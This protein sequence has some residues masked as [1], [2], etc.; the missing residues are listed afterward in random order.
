ML[1]SLEDSGGEIMNLKVKG[2][3]SYEMGHVSVSPELLEKASRDEWLFLESLGDMTQRLERASRYDLVRLSALLRQLLCDNPSLAP[4]VNRKF[5]LNIQFE[6]AIKHSKSIPEPQMLRTSWIT[7]Y[8]DTQEEIVC[9]DLAR[10]LK[11]VTI[12]HNGVACTVGDVIDVVAHAFG[13]V[14]YG[15]LWSDENKVLA[16]LE[17]EV[18]VHDE[19]LVLRSLH[20]IGKVTLKALIP[21][22]EA[23][24]LKLGEA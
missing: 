9:V 24:M 4:L 16:V 12:T 20:D 1:S 2:Q 11:L 6:A 7:L 19:S 10:F 18:L 17:H 23:I 13:G 22:A 15:Q 3:P 5:K 21:L 14:H 8:P